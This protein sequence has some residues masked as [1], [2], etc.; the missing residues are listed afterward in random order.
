[1][2]RLPVCVAGALLASALCAQ[3][4]ATPL[5][6]EELAFTA[7]RT[8]KL[9]AQTLEMPSGKLPVLANRSQPATRAEAIGQLYAI[10]QH[11]KPRF[12]KD[13]KPREV[14]I[15]PKDLGPAASKARELAKWG[16]VDAKDVLVVGPAKTLTPQQWGLSLGRFKA[17]LLDLTHTAIPGYSPQTDK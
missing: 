16:L 10:Y 17:W 12:R 3:K 2:I 8:M 9:F 7:D 6:R 5:T 11:Y 15:A 14:K 1:M 4:A 13:A